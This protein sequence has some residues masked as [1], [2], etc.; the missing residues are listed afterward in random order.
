MAQVTDI[1]NVK[2]EISEDVMSQLYSSKSF[3]LYL[4]ILNDLA[5]PADKLSILGSS[6]VLGFEK[7]I[8]TLPDLIE[9]DLGVDKKI[10]EELAYQVATKVLFPVRDDVVG[11]A[12]A[13]KAWNDNVDIKQDED[14]PEEIAKMVVS[15]MVGKGD[16]H[17]QKRL[18]H[19]L[20]DYASKEVD[21]EKTLALLTKDTQIGGVGFNEEDSKELIAAV[22]KKVA[23]I[24]VPEPKVEVPV[25]RLSRA[26]RLQRD[27][28]AKPEA[29]TE[30]VKVKVPNKRLPRGERLKREPVQGVEVKAELER[31]PKIEA[32]HTDDEKEVA[33]VAVKKQEAITVKQ[34]SPSSIEELVDQICGNPA[35]KFKDKVLMDRCKKV[36]ETRIRNVR[37]AQ[38]TRSHI[39]QSVDKGGL[40]VSGRALADML[41]AIEGHVGVYEDMLE[42]KA[43]KDKTE[44]IEK[45]IAKRKEKQGF[46]TKQEKVLSDRHASITGKV[47][48][49]VVKPVAPSGA[50]TSAAVSHEDSLTQQTR[51]VDKEKLNSA[52]KNAELDQIKENPKPIASKPVVKDVQSK[53]RLA[54]P[55]EE[56]RYMT[57]TDFR[58]LSK[59]PNQA[60]TKIMDSVELVQDQGYHKKVEAI[61]AWQASPVNQIYVSLTQRAIFES[62]PLEELRS[63][64]DADKTKMLT[65]EELAAVI[66][67]NTELRF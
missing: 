58:R 63:S 2:D 17:L 44:H 25:K 20:E 48:K 31:K 43:L 50:R 23:S 21:A 1:T 46:D 61:K 49:D 52:T 34:A 7:G 19:D 16:E 41:E 4:D 45:R 18:V 55:V 40:G 32:F 30:V 13:V 54:G 65:K 35:L 12:Q 66:K 39:E 5:I 51:R 3:D 60:I 64:Y 8:V 29:K 26:E 33:E 15:E 22:D 56:L 14:T 57:L 42:E 11:Y 10:A 37:T 53:K 67:L 47:S 6:V 9:K 24:V 36:V 27:P 59:D 62:S 28:V 38:Q